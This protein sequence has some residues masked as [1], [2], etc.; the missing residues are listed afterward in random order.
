MHP[1]TGVL[2]RGGQ[3]GHCRREVLGGS[4]PRE[5]S[6]PLGSPSVAC[7][8]PEQPQAVVP[9]PRARRWTELWV[10]HGALSPVTQQLRVRL[11][12]PRRGCM[13]RTGPNPRIPVRGGN[14]QES[15]KLWAPGCAPCDPQELGQGCRPK[16]HKHMC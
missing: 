3:R 4:L 8:A 1:G 12:S 11:G 9:M 14:G 6:W 13:V 16:L 5:Q 10:Q 2:Q 15:R 7:G